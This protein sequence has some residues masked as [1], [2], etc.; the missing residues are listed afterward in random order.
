MNPPQ[1]NPLDYA[2]YRQQYLNNLLLQTSN[3][4]LN[5]NANLIYKKTQQTPSELTDYRTTTEKFADTDSLRREVRSFL[6]TDGFVN[7]TEANE[8]AQNL[9]A[10]QLLFVVQYKDLIKSEFKGRGVPADVFIHYLLSLIQMSEMA[11]NTNIGLQQESGANIRLSTEQLYDVMANQDD[12]DD[13][14]NA[15][16]NSKIGDTSTARIAAQKVM[17]TSHATPT[18]AFRNAIEAA[19]LPAQ[20]T[21]QIILNEAYD[22][23]PTSNEIAIRTQQLQQAA[24]EGDTMLE[25]ELLTDIIQSLPAAVE[26]SEALHTAAQVL[27][28]DQRISQVSSPSNTSFHSVY[29]TPPPKIRSP[30]PLRSTQQRVARATVEDNN[31]VGER[32]YLHMAPAEFGRLPNQEQI[33]FLNKQLEDGNV[34]N[35]KTASLTFTKTRPVSTSQR[36]GTLMILFTKWQSQQGKD[37]TGHGFKLKGRG[38]RQKIEGRIEGEY[39]KPKPYKQF[40]RYLINREKLMNDILMLKRV[41]GSKVPDLPTQ[42]ISPHLAQI[43]REILKGEPPMCDD[44]LEED[45]G[46]LRQILSICRCNNMT[47]LAGGA[48]KSEEDKEMDRFDILRGEIQAGNDNKS[49]VKEFKLMLV[50][51]M[52]NGRIPR[53]QG[54]EI[55]TDIA[56]MGL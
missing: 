16:Q 25:L 31:R 24:R 53:R 2:K 52:N 23:F 12:Y 4:Q 5:L 32:D 35:L 21:V 14:L 48:V 22:S 44:M 9:D 3:N 10:N 56:A 26:A 15:I 55:L 7:S 13:L 19:S 42:R 33:D 43:L 34:P 11:V 30:I 36:R 40:G 49:I 45:Y 27:N 20:D 46:K 29:S 6:A 1:R 17:E 47:L 39:H 54:Q 28:D 37:K 8:V 18:K 41:G 51:F 50:K 38:L